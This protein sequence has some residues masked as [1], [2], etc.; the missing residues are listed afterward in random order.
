MVL[1]SVCDHTWLRY[2]L[3]L[4]NDSSDFSCIYLYTASTISCCVVMFRERRCYTMFNRNDCVYLSQIR[5]V[6]WRVKMHDTLSI[7]R[8]AGHLV[9]RPTRASNENHSTGN[10]RNARNRWACCVSTLRLKAGLRW[11][12]L[13]K[14]EAFC[15]SYYSADRNITPAS[16]SIFSYNWRR[17][18][19]ISELINGMGKKITARSLCITYCFV[20]VIYHLCLR[21]SSGRKNWK[22]G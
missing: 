5:L 21:G 10:V 6:W 8:L 1:F 12:V 15:P 13:E 4:R 14:G 3:L 17:V 9:S 2:L 11:T 16:T 22:K 7:D 20:Y 19:C 18:S